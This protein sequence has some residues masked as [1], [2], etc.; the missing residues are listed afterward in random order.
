MFASARVTSGCQSQLLDWP[1][2]LPFLRQQ[3][4]PSRIPA[5]RQFNPVAQSAASEIGG[6]RDPASMRRILAVRKDVAL[7]AEL[8]PK[9]SFKILC[10]R[11]DWKFSPAQKGSQAFPRRIVPQVACSPRYCVR[12]R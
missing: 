3:S 8:A 9:Q 12:S 1:V 5:V 6:F 7:R 2:S 10:R 11:F 4:S